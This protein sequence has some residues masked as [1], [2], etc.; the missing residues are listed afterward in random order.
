MKIFDSTHQGI[1]QIQ[2]NRTKNHHIHQPCMKSTKNIWTVVLTKVDWKKNNQEIS[3]IKLY[4]NIRDKYNSLGYIISKWFPIW[5][6]CNKILKI[7]IRLP[8]LIWSNPIE[9]G[10]SFLNKFYSWQKKHVKDKMWR[11]NLRLMNDFSV[12][13]S[14]SSYIALIRYR[15]FK[16]THIQKIILVY[17]KNKTIW[18][19][20]QI[21]KVYKWLQST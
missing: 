18:I 3:I 9:N 20:L 19:D 16:S 10:F 11:I 4:K 8:K 14:M 7:L 15:Y 6:L 13:T 21:T 5:T 12:L 1:Q 2:T 17:P